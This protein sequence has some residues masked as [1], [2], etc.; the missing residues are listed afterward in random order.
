MTRLLVHVEGQTEEK[1]INEVLASHLYNHGF[2]SVSARLIGNARQRNRRGGIIDWKPVKREIIK[3]L[4]E[5]KRRIVTMMVDYYGLPK[6]W[7]RRA[8]MPRKTPHYI[9][10]AVEEN[11]SIEIGKDMGNSFDSRRF[12]PYLMVHEFEALLFSDCDSFCTAIARD[13]LTPEFQHIRDSFENPEEID[14]SPEKAP[15]KRIE[16]LFPKYQK[17][18]HGTLSALK[19]GLDT[20][21]TECPHFAKW[22]NQLESLPHMY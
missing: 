10:K 4:K 11:L 14:D 8:T 12:I 13:D 2:S 17:P 15:S 3:H 5:D 6:T 18:V 20:M 16:A 19:I 22:M 7:P 21:R 1:F 9:A